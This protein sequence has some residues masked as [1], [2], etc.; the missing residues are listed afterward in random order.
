M[1]NEATYPL[2]VLFCCGVTQNFFDLPRDGIAEVWR[3]YGVMLKAIG[4]FQASCRLDG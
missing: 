4:R 3:A 1:E 2:R